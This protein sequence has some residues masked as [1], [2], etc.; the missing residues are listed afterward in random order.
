MGYTSLPIEPEMI[1]VVY[2]SCTNADAAAINV[3]IHIH[4]SHV[5]HVFQVFIVIYTLIVK[6]VF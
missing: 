2:N 1:A 3:F 4:I 5:S 6:V